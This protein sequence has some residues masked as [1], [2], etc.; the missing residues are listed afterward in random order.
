[1]NPSKLELSL[2]LV[3]RESVYRTKLDYRLTPMELYELGANDELVVMF[4]NEYDEY[5]SR[6]L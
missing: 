2:L 1:M 5:N 4:L 6:R 3:A